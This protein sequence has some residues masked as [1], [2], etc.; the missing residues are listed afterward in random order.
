MWLSQKGEVYPASTLGCIDLRF[1]VG[2]Y[3]PDQAVVVVQ[4]IHRLPVCVP[5]LKIFVAGRT[6]VINLVN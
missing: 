3:L 1:Q 2:S 6:T 5:V 4:F